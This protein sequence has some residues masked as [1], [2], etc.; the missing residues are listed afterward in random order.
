MDVSLREALMIQGNETLVEVYSD[1]EKINYGFVVYLMKDGEIHTEIISTVGFPF[2][3]EKEAQSY[4]DRYLEAVRKMDLSP[5]KSELEK[6]IDGET[7]NKMKK[8]F[9]K[10]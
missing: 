9:L 4:A 7:C 1:K 10:L 2:K 3:A 5:Q 8:E 6:I